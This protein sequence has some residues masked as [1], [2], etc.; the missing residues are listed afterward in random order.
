MERMDGNARPL[1][2]I[3]TRT[4]SQT[5]RL[6]SNFWGEPGGAC[7]L[8]PYPSVLLIPLRPSAG[9][10]RVCA[11]LLHLRNPCL[12]VG[13]VV[14]AVVDAVVVVIPSVHAPS[15]SARL[16]PPPYTFLLILLLLLRGTSPSPRCSP[17]APARPPSPSLRRSRYQSETGREAS[18]P[19][20]SARP[21]KLERSIC[22]R[23]K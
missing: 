8:Q 3:H 1:P 13:A 18:G 15:H 16:L 4:H 14:D 19:G 12:V 22:R 6:R 17:F 11:S 20:Q 21:C 9:V 10:F 23:A 5:H 7:W 2:S